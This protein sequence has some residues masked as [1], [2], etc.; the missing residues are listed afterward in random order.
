MGNPHAVFVVDDAMA[1]PAGVA[2]PAIENDGFFPQKTN[3]GFAQVLGPNK[4]RLR[5]WERGVGLTKACGT[6]ACAA[7]VALHRKGILG[8]KVEVQVD[9]GTLYIDWDSYDDR[10]RMTG[11]V[12]VETIGVC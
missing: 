8:R 7:V 2:G 9:G 4:I 6:G 10:I 1:V 12:E 5:V 11:P 3:V